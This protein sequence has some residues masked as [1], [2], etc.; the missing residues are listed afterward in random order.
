MR[1]VNKLDTAEILIE[2]MESFI[3]NNVTTSKFKDILQVYYINDPT[4]VT[5]E[6]METLDRPPVLYITKPKLSKASNS[7]YLFLTSVFGIASMS[8]FSLYPFALNTDIANRVEQELTLST[9]PDLSFLTDLSFPIFASFLGLQLFHEVGHW[10]VARGYNITITPPTFIPNPILGITGT[11]TSFKT[12]PK[13]RQEML[14]VAVTGPLVAIALSIVTMY[15]GLQLTLNTD[16][17]AYANLPK[18]PIS[19][20]Y[21]S[22][23]G[24]GIIE[25][26]YGSGT[27]N[28]PD[29]TTATMNLHPLVISGY[30][31]LLVNAL[32]LIPFGRTDGG[33]ISL[34]LFGRTGKQLIDFI[35]LTGLF[36]LGL[37]ASD[38]FLFYVSFLLFLQGEPEIPCRNEVDEVDFSRVILSI[39]AGFVVLLTVIPMGASSF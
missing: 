28:V 37:F 2:R 27:L 25:S 14:D 38:A 19:F 13:N 33:R 21:Q 6:Q 23:L 4:P 9:N 3:D 5:D 29:L 8:V 30:T 18:L 31:S 26:V 34:A 16:P 7:I 36:F 12:S 35:A 10:L 11:I 24:A 20:L 22:S 17:T 15:V 1:G 32:Q 39:F